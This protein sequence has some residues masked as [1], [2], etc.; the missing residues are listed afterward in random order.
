MGGSAGPDAV[1]GIDAE[2]GGGMVEVVP[3][4]RARA[5]SIAAIL[6]SRTIC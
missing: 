6:W 1:A 2:V 5:A 4:E 3:A